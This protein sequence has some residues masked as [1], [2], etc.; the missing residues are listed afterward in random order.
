MR[1]IVPLPEGARAMPRRLSLALF[2]LHR[3][4]SADPETLARRARLAEDAGFES[5]WVGD[6]IALPVEDGDNPAREARLEALTV[7]AHLAALTRRV[8]LALRAI[9]MPQRQ[10]VLL[11]K[12]LTSIDVLSNGRLIVGIGVGYLEPELKALGASLADRGARTDEYLAAMRALWDEPGPTF[13]GRFVSF[14]GLVHRP[15]PA[16]RP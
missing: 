3:G 11:A 16:Q 15:R 7:L 9:V 6:H 5:F 2:G 13:E 12:Q 10:P 8:R 14:A 4:S 1:S